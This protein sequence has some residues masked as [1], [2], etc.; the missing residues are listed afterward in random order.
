[1]KAILVSLLVIVATNVK[2]NELQEIRFD[3]AGAPVH[4]N[5]VIE[6]ITRNMTL[7]NPRINLIRG[8]TVTFTQK[9]L[10]LNL[11]RR[12]QCPPNA[13]CAMVMPAPVQI[14]LTVYKVE[15]TECSVKYSAATPANIKSGIYE[16][17]IVEDFTFSKCPVALHLPYRAGVVTYKVKGISS[18]TKKP[19]TA[20]AT[21]TV[22]EF[23]RAVN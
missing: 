14:S 5:L 10:Q 8:A 6:G 21:F 15:N 2:A 18:L 4:A 16:Q 7:V 19:E 11:T 20:S 17:V 3:G 9:S 13:M 12:M 1:M 23:I 22:P